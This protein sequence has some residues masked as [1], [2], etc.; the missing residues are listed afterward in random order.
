MC[1]KGFWSEFIVRKYRI[2]ASLLII[3]SLL[4]SACVKKVTIPEALPVF[5]ALSTDDL[6]KRVNSMVD[7][8]TFSGQT[9]FHVRNYFTGSARKAAEY[10][11]ADGLIRLKRPSSIRMQIK[12]PVVGS[13]VADMVSDGERFRIAIYLPS[14]KR[15]FIKGSN[16]QS[17]DQMDASELQDTKDP[18]LKE[19]GGLVNIRPQHFIDA[20]FIKPLTVADGVNIFRE[21]SREVEPDTR[22]GKA[23]RK[24]EKIYYILYVV[25]R[26]GS[27][28]GVLR[29]KFWFDRTQPGTPLVRQQTF[30]TSNG[31]IASDIVYSDWFT[32]PEA[33][34]SWPRRTEIDRRG[35]GYKFS[36]SLEKDSVEFNSEL[37]VTTFVLENTE[38]LEEINLDVQRKATSAQDNAPKKK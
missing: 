15:R 8:E 4:G 33:N 10:P 31:K 23:G 25:E 28:Y 13:K 24:V 22:V 17:L 7:V 12:L 16:L 18:R 27:G 3:V 14:D 6:V 30:E 35:D 34:R 19:A 11:E 20:F 29:R 32:A 2:L 9:V 21:E 37:P 38:N 26:N 5:P 1:R 36:L